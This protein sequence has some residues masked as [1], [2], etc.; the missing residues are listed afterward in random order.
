MIQCFGSRSGRIIIILPDP[1]PDRLPRLADPDPAYLTKNL[2]NF[3]SNK[4]ENF[5]KDML[6]SYTLSNLKFVINLA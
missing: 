1:D 3:A 4:A 6:Q 2:H 5:W